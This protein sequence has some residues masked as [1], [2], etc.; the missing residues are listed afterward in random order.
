MLALMLSLVLT[1]LL[2]LLLLDPTCQE[3]CQCC[4]AATTAVSRQV[5]KLCCCQ[6]Q[7]HQ[8][9][10]CRGDALEQ[11]DASISNALRAEAVTT[12]AWKSTPD[13]AVTCITGATGSVLQHCNHAQHMHKTAPGIVIWGEGL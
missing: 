6:G 5:R 8:G 9:E 13:A 7:A 4:T 11:V 12:T 2:L 1:I 3:P 10:R